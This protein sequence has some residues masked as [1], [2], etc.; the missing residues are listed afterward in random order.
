MKCPKCNSE[1]N[2]KA[3]I[4][5]GKQR[6]KC[7][8]CGYNFTVERKSNDKSQIK[9]QA[10]HL[11]L[12]GYKPVYIAKILKVSYV[13]IYKWIKGYGDNIKKDRAS[14]KR[15]KIER[16]K[17]IANHFKEEDSKDDSNGYLFIDLKKDNTES[18]FCEPFKVIFTNKNN[19][20]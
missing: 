14:I 20:N 11:Y 8:D 3:G 1:N 18:F 7:K 13:S 4:V 2:I 12:E 15:I 16:M 6:Y 5:K 10:I 9:R 17:N 19:N